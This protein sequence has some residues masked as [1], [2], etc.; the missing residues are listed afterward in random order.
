MDLFDDT[1]LRVNLAEQMIALDQRDKAYGLLDTLY[2]ENK[3][4]KCVQKMLVKLSLAYMIKQR[5]KRGWK[6]SQNFITNVLKSICEDENTTP[7]SPNCILVL[8]N[9]RIVLK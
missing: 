7:Y 1:H 2:Q 4:Y 3:E 9:Q 8:D 6:F 5:K